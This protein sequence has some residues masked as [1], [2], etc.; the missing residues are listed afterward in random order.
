MGVAT[1]RNKGGYAPGGGDTGDRRGQR[2]RGN[3][4]VEGPALGP[5]AT[6]H[7]SSVSA[8]SPLDA[9]FS[10][11]GSGT[12][13]EANGPQEERQSRTQGS[14]PSVMP[15]SR[16]SESA[17]V[18][19][20]PRG[21][22]LSAQEQMEGMLCRKQEMEAFGKKAANRYRGWPHG[23]CLLQSLAFG[24]ASLE[25]LP[26]GRGRGPQEECP[27]GRGSGVGPRSRVGPQGKA[28]RV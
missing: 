8:T 28:K 13:D 24:K 5:Q 25:P 18:A 1:C 7:P 3:W 17:R 10:A 19:T 14:A 16:S 15:Q 23:A 9:P 11:Q 27:L 21:P 26:R 12:G 4:A 22:E 2:P 20:L 6:R